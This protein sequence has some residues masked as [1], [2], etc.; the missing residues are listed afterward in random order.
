MQ[1]TRVQAAFYIAA[2]LLLAV[3]GIWLMLDPESLIS[4]LHGEST[5]GISPLMGRQSGLGLLL[6]SAGNILCLFLA[7]TRVLVH[8]VIL[9]Y[10]I[11]MVASHGPHAFSSAAWLW[12][13]VLAYAVP[14]I[15]VPHI[16][17]GE[18]KGEVKWFNP[19]KGF[20]F[21]ITD[22]GREI[23]VHFKAVR[24]GGRRSLK[25][26]AR[27]RFRV[28]ETDRGEQADRVYIES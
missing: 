13:V 12:L 24:N 18:V 14:V 7:R 2:A 10:L 6:A 20:G 8:G 11:A 17:I 19:N 5:T 22:D 25:N 16:G 3:P 9:V 26:G 15:P 4:Q 1:V 27:V 23:F 28:R 21:I